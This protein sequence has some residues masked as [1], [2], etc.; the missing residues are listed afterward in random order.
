MLEGF[1]G[2]AWLFFERA[3]KVEQSSGD[4]TAST[5]SHESDAK[6]RKLVRRAACLPGIESQFAEPWPESA[7][8]VI[9]NAADQ[10]AHEG[11]G[12]AW[13]P[14]LAWLLIDSLAMDLC[15]CDENV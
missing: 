4:V 9:P 6:F 13:A 7:K 5:R 14:V 11:S 2:H 8:K 12:Q 3:L 15:G 1:F 10:T